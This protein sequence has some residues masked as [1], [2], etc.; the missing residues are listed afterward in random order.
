MLSFTKGARLWPKRV[1]QGFRL[2]SCIMQGGR[3]GILHSAT[4]PREAGKMKCPQQNEEEPLALLLES[5]ARRWL[6]ICA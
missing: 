2:P 4:L 1:E 6:M 3:L 5:V